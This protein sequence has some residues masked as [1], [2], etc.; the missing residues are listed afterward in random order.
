MNAVH[1]LGKVSTD[2]VLETTSSG[3]RICRFKMSTSNGRGLQPTRHNIVIWGK[4][5]TDEHPANVHKYVKA[6]D[7]VQVTGKIQENRWMPKGSTEWRSRIEIVCSSI[8]FIAKSSIQ[9]N[10]GETVNAISE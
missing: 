9:D 3:R 8:E 6:G 10:T 7:K 5:P 4:S 1:L 2:P